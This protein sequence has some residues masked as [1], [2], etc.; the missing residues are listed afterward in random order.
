MAVLMLM[1]IITNLLRGMAEAMIISYIGSKHLVHSHLVIIQTQLTLCAC[2]GAANILQIGV[3]SIE[4][5][6]IDDVVHQ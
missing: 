1:S 4:I 3:L 2:M 6:G 5:H